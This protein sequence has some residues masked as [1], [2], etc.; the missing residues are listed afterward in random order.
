M[1]FVTA[2]RMPNFQR[3]RE[4]RTILKLF[5]TTDLLTPGEERKSSS[6]DKIGT[7]ELRTAATFGSAIVSTHKRSSS[8]HTELNTARHLTG[9]CARL[10]VEVL[11]ARNHKWHR[12]FL[13]AITRANRMPETGPNC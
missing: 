4:P 2:N 3:C 5:R 10:F 8:R 12:S 7:V 9:S 13:H 1:L 6:Q 11:D